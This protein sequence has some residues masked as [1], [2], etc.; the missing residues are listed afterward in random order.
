VGAWWAGG[1]FPLPG[2]LSQEAR[3]LLLSML[4]VDPLQRTTIDKIK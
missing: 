2:H 1:I 3:E 4:V